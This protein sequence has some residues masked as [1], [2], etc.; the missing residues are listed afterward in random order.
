MIGNLLRQ[1]ITENFE[2]FCSRFRFLGP[3]ARIHAEQLIEAFAGN[4]HAVQCQ[5]RRSWHKPNRRIGGGGASLNP[6]GDPLQHPDIFAESGPQEFSVGILAEPIHVENFRRVFNFRAHVQPVLEI[7]GHVVAAERDHGHRIATRN[8]HGAGG[9]SSRFR[10]H[11]SSKENAVIPVPR[12]VD[13]GR[14]LGPASAENNRGNGNSF[15]VFPMR[16][17]RGRL[18][19]RDGITRI[20]MRRRPAARRP[21]LAFPVDQVL[22]RLGSNPFPPGLAGN[23]SHR[24]IG[25][26]CVVVERSHHVRIGFKIR[27][28]R[29]AEKS[30]FGV[31]RAQRAVFGHMHPG[32]IV[33]DG[34]YSVAFFFQRR[35]HHGEI[36]FAARTGKRGCH[37]RRLAGWT[38]QPE[39]QHVL[40]HPTLFARHKAG[41]A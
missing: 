29:H 35:N 14:Q 34:L 36:C 17:N 10:C 37:V 33:A 15:G 5:R 16:R 30:C 7:I 23:R 6:I 9:G 19:S 11:G 26:N 20:R 25:E 32:D 21:L 13:Q 8:S 22:V 24:G 38:F 40:R 18:V 39:Q 27:A 31:H 2:E 4:V 12:F 3:V 1:S 28:G 41:D